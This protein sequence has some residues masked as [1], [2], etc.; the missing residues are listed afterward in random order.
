MS[1]RE[2]MNAAD[3]DAMAKA[4]FASPSDA[5]LTSA[6]T[7]RIPTVLRSEFTRLCRSQDRNVSQVLRGLMRQYISESEGVPR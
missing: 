6:L 3:V 1:A 2:R 7:I 5:E 4:V